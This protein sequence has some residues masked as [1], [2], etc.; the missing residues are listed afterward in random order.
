LKRTLGL[1]LLKAGHHA[2]AAEALHEAVRQ[3]PN[4][5]DA[6]VNRG[7]AL[8]LAGRTREAIGVLREALEL[9]PHRADVLNN[10]GVAYIATGRD[11]SA[12]VNL[13]RAAKHL[14]SPR[15]L[16]NLG[17]IHTDMEETAGARRAYEQVLQLRPK[18][19]EALAGL[20]RVGPTTPSP[21]TGRIP[22]K[23]AAKSKASKPPQGRRRTRSTPREKSTS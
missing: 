2:A 8:L 14:E 19:P 11:R 20:K 18:D 1:A 12:V 4:D 5:V 22:R 21:P 23:N 15:I 16:L 6:Q 17:K 7:A 10:L 9:D 13:E 3:N